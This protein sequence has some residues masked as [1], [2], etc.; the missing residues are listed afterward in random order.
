MAAIAQVE[1]LTIGIP[2]EM[3][4]GEGEDFHLRTTLAGAVVTGVNEAVFGMNE[5]LNGS[6]FIPRCSSYFNSEAEINTDSSIT[7]HD[8]EM[9][10]NTNTTNTTIANTINNSITT[11]IPIISTAINNTTITDSTTA[12][13][14]TI[15]HSTVVF[16]PFSTAEAEHKHSNNL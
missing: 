5:V 2:D 12:S 4:L 15:Q 10:N 6:F 16:S 11:T 1:R 14:S 8:I 3:L 7:D 13:N 9:H